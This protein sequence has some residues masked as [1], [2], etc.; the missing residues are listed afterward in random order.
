MS[1]LSWD[2]FSDDTAGQAPAPVVQQP[3][4]PAPVQTIAPVQ[5]VV[6][7]MPV[8][9]ARLEAKQLLGTGD[10]PFMGADR[11]RAEDK[12]IICGNSDVNQ[13]IPFKYGWAWSKYLDASANHWMPQEI[14]M[15]AD[16]ALWKSADGLTENER[17]MVMRTLGFFSVADTMVANNLVTSIYNNVTAPEVRQY[18]LVQIKEE[19]IHAHSYQYCI[20]SLGM[21]QGEVFNMYREVQ[22]IAKKMAW[23]L[24]V[25]K[26]LA[27]VTLTPEST[28]EQIGAFIKHL[29]AYYCV[30][31]GVFF[32]CGFVQLLSLGRRNK[33][34]GV[35][36]QIEYILRDES[37]HA[38][39][40]IDLIN[41]IKA[42]YPAAWTP[43]LQAEIADLLLEG[44]VL[45]VDY[46]NDTLPVGII[47]L[48]ANMHDDYL[49]II[50]N[51]RCDQLGIRHVFDDGIQHPY[52][53][54]SEAMDIRKEKNFFEARVTDYQVGGALTW[55]D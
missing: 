14:P 16:I 6:L 35:R 20:E 17:R 40:G 9:R 39:F 11:I 52:A 53:W 27:D 31:E 25:T 54:L 15:Q 4:Q 26:A 5:P 41:Q 19:A 24:Q 46:I 10:N 43:Q 1:I 51:R 21:D 42:E 55:N 12:R 49:Q 7:D 34:V 3:V 22:S 44:Y 8:V 30:V 2:D 32:Y 13:L 18:L 36:E 48:N 33:L 47:G 29:A 38:N 45:E 50:I 28:P 37:M 23:A